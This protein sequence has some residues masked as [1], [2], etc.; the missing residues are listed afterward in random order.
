MSDIV[1]RAAKTFVQAAL[2]AWVVTNFSFEKT[3][4]LAAVAAGISAVWNVIVPAVKGQYVYLL[5]HGILTT[6]SSV[7][8][9]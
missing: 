8:L 4:V 3:A 5:L 7:V 2:A 1:I 9:V 6:R